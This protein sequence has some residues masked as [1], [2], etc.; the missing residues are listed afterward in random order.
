MTLPSSD[1]YLTYGGELVNY[2]QVEDPNTDL[3]ADAS[4]QLR[5]SAAGLSNTA[6]RAIFTITVDDVAQVITF[7]NLNAVWDVGNSAAPTGVYR[8]VGW[9]RITFPVQVT[10]LRGNLQ[11]VN[12]LG[13]IANP[14]VFNGNGFMC[15]VNKT[16]LSPNVIDIFI[17]SIVDAQLEDMGAGN[18][19]NVMVR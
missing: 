3:D 4:N 8:G 17:F 19:I 7:T 2:S 1:S 16:G 15:T 10:D 9:Y 13:G 5:A 18:P 6:F 14:D 11:Y 12:L